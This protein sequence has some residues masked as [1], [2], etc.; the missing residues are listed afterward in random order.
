VL[1]LTSIARFRIRRSAESVSLEP[2]P[3]TPD[4]VSHLL[5]AAESVDD[6]RRQRLLDAAAVPG[7]WL[8]HLTTHDAR[9]LGRLA[10]RLPTIVHL[11]AS[12]A[13]T[14]EIR[15]RFGGWSTWSAEQARST[16]CACIAACLNERQ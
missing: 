5:R 12:G 15:R 7:A 13:S 6:E 16:A 1:V 4:E 11:H 10:D 2:D 3:Y 14:E 9:Q 8:P